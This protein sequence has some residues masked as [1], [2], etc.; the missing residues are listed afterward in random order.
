MPKIKTETLLPSV[1]A[2]EKKWVIPGFPK[3]TSQHN[4]QRHTQ[5]S[6]YTEAGLW[7]IPCDYTAL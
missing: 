4:R 3:A 1:H 7:T 6:H 5:N 2:S